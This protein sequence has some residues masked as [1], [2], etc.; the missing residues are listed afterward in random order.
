MG[1]LIPRRC[2]CF[3]VNNRQF[4]AQKKQE[5]NAAKDEASQ[6]ILEMVT[7]LQ[8]VVCSSCEGSG[9]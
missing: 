2:I 1:F 7:R 6:K 5:M 3:Y 9:V 4:P 8:C